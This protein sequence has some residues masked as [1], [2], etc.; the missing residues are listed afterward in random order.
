MKIL[1]ATGI[2][3]VLALILA[4]QLANESY[5]LAG[6][7]GVAALWLMIEWRNEARAEAW[8]MAFCVVGYTLGNRGFAQLSILSSFPL[9]PAELLL[10]GAVPA[11]IVR[12]AMRKALP[13]RQDALNTAILLWFALGMAR[14]PL[15]L[16]QN[17]IMALRDFALVLYSLL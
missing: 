5:L 6:L 17:G 8:L 13:F 14:I 16:K 15:D 4:G 11:L 7:V 12:T 2:G 10:L 3:C 1:I 9:L